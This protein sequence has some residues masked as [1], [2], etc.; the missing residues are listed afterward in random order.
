VAQQV[1]DK[2]SLEPDS[3]NVKPTEG[4]ASADPESSITDLEETL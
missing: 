3:A 2:A 1:L 4:A